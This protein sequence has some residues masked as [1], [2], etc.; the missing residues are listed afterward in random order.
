MT[1][2]N[3]KLW[4]PS[5]PKEKELSD[6]M[7][8][9]KKEDGKSFPVLL[10]K[11]HEYIPKYTN[12]ILSK[13]ASKF[14]HELKQ[15]SESGELTDSQCAVLD[16]FC[17]FINEYDKNIPET[18]P[19]QLLYNESNIVKYLFS[20]TN[21]LDLRL[22]NII[23][24]MFEY[25]PMIIVKWIKKNYK[26]L[27]PLIKMA[28][29]TGNIESSK[30]VQRLTVSN[31]QEIYP[32]LVPFI[33][34]LL[35]TYPVSV[36]IDFMI[37]SK[38]MKEVIPESKFEE[39]LLQHPSFTI[40]D[41][42]VVTKFYNFVWMNE[43]SSTLLLRSIPPDKFKDLGW[44]HR[45]EP[46]N[47]ELKEETLNECQSKLLNNKYSDDESRENDSKRTT[48]YFVYLFVLSLGNPNNISKEVMDLLIN[49]IYDENEN[50]IL[51]S[52]AVQCFI[53]WVSKYNFKISPNL[54]FMICSI[55]QSE[56]ISK[57]YRSLCSAALIVFTKILPVAA[58][59]L[60]EDPSV[61]F[62]KEQEIP[63]KRTIWTFPH[64]V[65]LIPS[66]L[67]QKVYDL[68]QAYNVLGYMCN[69]LFE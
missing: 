31:M 28:S 32:L 69:F 23:V 54:V 17:F 38:E 1:S 48:I 15:T 43:T 55:I 35:T 61:R 41:I 25:E 49:F 7:A 9:I 30:L 26:A 51:A 6:I 33:K 67:S 16:L 66:I 46:Q 59:I 52:A 58:S 3:I 53:Y 11:L 47:Y 21:K 42:E 57:Q 12:L 20:H 18:N 19:F 62:T 56:K 60:M 36:V 65:K 13:L 63:L 22:I 37:S 29:E 5:T 44:M 45:S 34:P 50:E 68:N 8:K 40:S 39:W 2:I 24:S 64:F 14:V 10:P 4:K 27:Q